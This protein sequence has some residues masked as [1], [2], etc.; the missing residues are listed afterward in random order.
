M[1]WE[2]HATNGEVDN[3]DVASSSQSTFNIGLGALV[4]LADENVEW[5]G[6]TEWVFAVSWW[7]WVIDWW[8]ATVELSVVDLHGS[9]EGWRGGQG[10]NQDLSPDDTLWVNTV[11]SW[12]QDGSLNSNAVENQGSGLV[13]IEQEVL[14]D[15]LQGFHGEVSHGEGG[16][17]N[18]DDDG[19]S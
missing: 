12:S 5:G 15:S 11:S 16:S 10:V 3:G 8:Q 4:I 2:D 9:T 18:V 13:G 6:R 1:W 14:S 17:N 19:G 7:W